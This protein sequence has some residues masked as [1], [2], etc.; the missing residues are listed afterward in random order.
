MVL[1]SHS[2]TFILM[3]SRKSKSTI[4]DLKLVVL[5]T[6]LPA[7]SFASP[8]LTFKVF[9]ELHFP[10]SSSL[11]H[12]RI[13][14]IQLSHNFFQKACEVFFN[15]FITLPV[16]GKLLLKCK[17]LH[18]F[19]LAAFCWHLHKPFKGHL[20]GCCLE[21]T[22]LNWRHFVLGTWENLTLSFTSKNKECMRWTRHSTNTGDAEMRKALPLFSRGSQAGRHRKIVS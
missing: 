18:E 10:D 16:N 11:Q 3:N 13:Y 15:G 2:N 12:F 17:C 7:F 20:K 4:I 6:W 19:I 21:A 9:E 14:V 22:L 5:D 8:S 1:N